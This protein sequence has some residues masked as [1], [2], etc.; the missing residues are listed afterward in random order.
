MAPS[1]LRQFRLR[2]GAEPLGELP[3]LGQ[4]WAPRQEGRPSRT[5]TWLRS[6]A[7][8][9]ISRR[10]EGSKCLR[11]QEPLSCCLGAWRTA[12]TWRSCWA[13]KR[14]DRGC[15]LPLARGDSVPCLAQSRSR[16]IAEDPLWSISRLGALSRAIMQ[17]TS[18]SLH[19]GPL[20]GGQGPH[21]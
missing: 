3:P 16:E 4:D 6:W 18:P 5:W 8:A 9:Q 1:C 2:V 20:Q 12:P 21:L 19:P 11:L 13:T 15:S 10:R 17:T 14:G 7:P